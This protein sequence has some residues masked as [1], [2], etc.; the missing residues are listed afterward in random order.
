MLYCLK[1]AVRCYNWHSHS[2]YQ[3][4]VH[5]LCHQYWFHIIMRIYFEFSSVGVS[6]FT[7]DSVCMCVSVYVLICVSGCL[8]VS[9]WLI[10]NECMIY[11]H[12]IGLSACVHPEL[13]GH[14]RNTIILITLKFV[15]K[16][17]D[18]DQKKDQ[19]QRTTRETAKFGWFFGYLLC[20]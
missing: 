10:G 20:L 4:L 15:T 16:G 18:G 1:V 12:C 17:K 8:Y 2:W 13:W 5:L 6:V 9:M 14:Y 3:L 19:Q 7:H 11:T